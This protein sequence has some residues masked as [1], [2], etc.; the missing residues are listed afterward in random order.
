MTCKHLQ[1]APLE[2]LSAYLPM[3]TEYDSTVLA[4]WLRY[5]DQ[6]RR[7]SAV[8]YRSWLFADQSGPIMAFPGLL[9]HPISRMSRS[10]EALKMFRTVLLE[11]RRV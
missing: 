3:G 11:M 1:I 8:G 9:S 7:D 10:P 5:N 6:T 2:S 4:C